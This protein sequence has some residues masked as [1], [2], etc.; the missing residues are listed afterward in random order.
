MVNLAFTRGTFI[1][2]AAAAV[3]FATTRSLSTETKIT[4]PLPE[5][6]QA[7]GLGIRLT[8]FVQI[9][10]EPRLNMFKAL[11]DGRMFINDQRGDFYLVN[12]RHEVKAP[13]V[14][15]ATAPGV[16]EVRR[17]LR[18]QDYV[19]VFYPKE[20]NQQVG[21]LSFAF[22]PNFERN[23]VF[24]TVSTA[25]R[26]GRADFPSKRPIHDRHGL[27]VEA[28]HDDV[29]HRWVARDPAAPTFAGTV[30]EL[31]RIEEPYRDHNTGEIAFNPLARPGDEDYGLL[32]IGVADGGS[33]G[34]PVSKTDPLDNGQDLSTPLGAILRIDPEAVEASG[35]PYGI[36]GSNPFAGDA[37]PST[38]GEIYAYGLRNP[39]RLAWD[40]RSGHLLVFEIGQWLIEEID[41]VVAGGNYGWGDR[42]GAWVIDERDEHAL[43]PLPSDDEQFG[44]RYPWAMYDHPGDPEVPMSGAGAIA[45]GYV[46][47]GQDIPYLVDRVVFA[48]FTVDGRFFVLDEGQVDD[49]AY[50]TEAA[51]RTL[52]VYDVSGRPSTASRIIHGIDGR[53]TDV[54]IG[55]DHRG[56]LFVTNK[57]NGWVYKLDGV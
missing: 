41:V 34:F 6:V 55:Q 56:E 38:L 21:F 24:Y 2:T 10:G 16:M 37:N 43:Y 54:R 1:L 8:P 9:S 14:T 7:S 44:F 5:P 30:S 33:D 23:G 18:L 39:H 45:G 40:P 29:L 4:D 17:Y 57:H 22:H 28:D 11:P 15:E 46:Y 42:E 31:M 50:P 12:R 53:R 27:V 35:R 26:T 48:D 36:P 32:Y 19:E 20:D 52:E 25:R 3:L 49:G 13:S 47:R 51:V